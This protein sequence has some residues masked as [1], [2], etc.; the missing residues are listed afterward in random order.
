MKP[1]SSITSGYWNRRGPQRLGP[2]YPGIKSPPLAPHPPRVP[3]QTV[4]RF[5]SRS[6]RKTLFCTRYS[7]KSRQCSAIFELAAADGRGAAQARLPD[8]AIG[9]ADRV[10]ED[11]VDIV[12]A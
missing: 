6:P 2:G 11:D 1:R 9:V 7:P 8:P 3:D 10:E 5:G 12:V 4:I